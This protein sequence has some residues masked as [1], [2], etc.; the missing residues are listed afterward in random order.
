MPF[1][2]VN[3]TDL[4]CH[5]MGEGPAV[6][7]VHPPFIGSSVFNYVKHDLARDHRVVVFDIRGHGHSPAGDAA[8]TIPL[9]AEDIRQLLDRLD[10]E[11]AY[12]CG[13][14]C[15]AMPVLEALLSAPDRFRGAVLLSGASELTD[16]RSRM[17]MR[18]GAMLSN[19]AR[20][21]VVVPVAL[22]NAD[23]RT[24]F[25]VLH[26]EGRNGDA[27][28]CREYADSCLRYS[29]SDRLSRIDH[30]VLL[31]SGAEDE[32]GCA[33]A[34]DMHGRLRESEWYKIRGAGHHLP[35]KAPDQTCSVI[36]AWIAKLEGR[37]E[38]SAF[39]GMDGLAGVLMADEADAA[40]HERER[41]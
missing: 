25:G 39:A 22:G 20:E 41:G 32:T 23:S 3:G 11:S 26:E 7:M 4:H 30:P 28:C 8:V 31:L 24:T 1:L 37:D 21:A 13:Y 12:A 27:R 9:I 10:I 34:R 6:V 19:L 15:G 16:R 29:C 36:R 33:Y 2:H 35:T 18:A 40:A 17:Q 14:S 38:A 5:A